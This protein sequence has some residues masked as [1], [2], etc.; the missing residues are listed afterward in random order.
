MA[1]RGTGEAMRHLGLLFREGAVAGY[2][3]GQ[4]L[5]QFVARR[6]EAAEAA[7]AAL[8][9]RHGPMVLGVCRRALPDPLDAEDAFQTTFL[10]LARKAGSV[11]VG[12][13]L[14]RWLY[15]VS[16]RVSARARACVGRR[17]DL[18][19]GLAAAGGRPGDASPPADRLDLRGVLDDELGRLPAKYRDPLVLCYLQGQTHEAAAR[20]LG[21]PVGTVRGRMARGRDLLRIRLLRR[22]LA[23]SAALLGVSAEARASVPTLLAD[24]T[25]RAGCRVATGR[26]ASGAASA[27]VVA[28]AGSE[29]TSMT[30]AR[31]QA[32]AAALLVAGAALAAA[33][34][35]AGSWLAARQL[36]PDPAPKA[37]SPAREDR[38]EILGTWTS[39]DE[40]QETVGGV[41][42][43]PRLARTRWVITA[44]KIAMAD[45][46]GF[47]D[48]EIR[49]TL[50]P[51]RTPKAI[52]LTFLDS[53][54]TLPGLYRL[55]GD[56]L[57]LD[58]G[59]ERPKDLKEGP[60]RLL[61]KL[62]REG[63][64]PKLL[65]SRFELAPGCHWAI[66]PRGAIPSSVGSNGIHA[67]VEQK[68]PDG[69]M[70]II[71][72]H[73]R[74]GGP[75]PG[76]EIRP[77]LFDAQG[78]R[79][80]PKVLEGGS[81]AGLAVPGAM[82]HHRKYRLDPAD[83]PAG[84]AANFGVEAVP[85]EVRRATREAASAEAIGR[86]RARGIDLLPW[87]RV[88]QPYEFTLET[89]DGR[90]VRSLDLKG[91]VVLIDCWA[92]WCAPC[93]SKMPKLKELYEK[94]HGEGFEVIGV[95]LDDDP[96]NAHR[97]L[98]TL[99]LPWPEVFVPTD[100]ATRATWETAAGIENLPRLL[101]IDRGG[102]L[103]YDGGPGEVEG[104]VARWLAESVPAK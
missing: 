65:A 34:L 33:G 72:A 21:W 25:A 74:K 54:A 52:D 57:T 64:S 69:S 68:G 62:R 82:L 6:G 101:V 88:G 50:D 38:G 16:R 53:G 30:M 85:S 84:K 95:N 48:R 71:L 22:G 70:T 41:P 78:R 46:Q 99:A 36:P 43:P 23:P 1:A 96:E 8:V 86:A 59:L 28:W 32:I 44:D 51:T 58:Y 103:R 92:T 9:E 79:H 67:M 49:Y 100:E 15:G 39:D 14:G 26:W 104:Q 7:F 102:V 42:R 19:R 45:E 40:V 56:D 93:M 60:G 89:G 47:L 4:L 29:L 75:D 73:M 12:D 91:K 63:R 18:E 11:R 2:P 31:C 81:N 27:R 87:P 80:L 3:D 66:A 76:P 98:K 55:D 17:L 77:V 83:L 94:R 97:V 20:Q 24:L 61:H 13:S 35:G 37:A 10:I 5:E 90:V